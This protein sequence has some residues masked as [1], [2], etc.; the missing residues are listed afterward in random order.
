MEECILSVDQSTQGTKALLFGREGELLVRRDIPHRQHVDKQGWVEHD[1]E[2]I[3]ANVLE[4]AG[5]VVRESG[6][7]AAGIRAVGLTNQ[8]E[9]ALA[10]DR[11]TGR[12]IYNAIVW[13]C[14]RGEAICAE[15]MEQ[16][17]AE[18]ARAVTGL[19]L[20]PY[21]SASKLAWLMRNVPEAKRL[22]GEGRLC[23]GTIDTWLVFR[24]TGGREFR[25]DFSNA[26]R[27]QLFN[28][29]TLEWDAHACE[30][31]G[32][33]ME[34]LPELTASDGD[35]GSTDFG[36]QLP[37]RVPIR[38][39]MGD[40]NAALFGQGCTEPGMVKATYGTGSSVMM[41]TGSKLVE[42]KKLATSIAW[43]NR[44]NITYVLEG[45][46]NY[47]GAVITWLKDD[48]LMIGSPQETDQL[49]RTANPADTT[50]LVPAF[51]G[52]GAPYWDP[53]AHAVACGMSR[54][55]GRAEFVKAALESIAYQV[56]DVVT[57]MQQDSSLG[58]EELRTDG[59]A[60]G[61]EYL[62]QFQSDIIGRRVAISATAELSALGAAHMAGEAIG[63]Y[64]RMMLAAA[65]NKRTLEPQMSAAERD[66]KYSGWHQAVRRTLWT[67]PK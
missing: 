64:D 42:S 62:M 52:L 35:F 39:V 2:E 8:R 49:A 3:Y 22:A 43:G 12:P 23:I 1:P 47:S 15:L 11:E 17:Y 61:N 38:A 51:S 59:G 45:N 26:A 21:F 46:I 9:T 32:I 41:N 44:E 63:L 28:I 20:S 25:T 5:N 40:S 67:P 33:P 14:A 36:G 48:M 19:T 13:Q 18:Q 10:W 66:M 31:F 58:I 37:E 55:T 50:Y 57:A 53:E 7:D 65:S 56:A 6:I 4:V 30:V 60:T 24:L 54:T 34:A 29:H 16:G 27:T